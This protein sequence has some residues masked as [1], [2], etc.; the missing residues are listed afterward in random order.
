[1]AKGN[2]GNTVGVSMK[3]KKSTGYVPKASTGSDKYKS[4]GHSKGGYA[5]QVIKK[6]Q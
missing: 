6:G 2:S 4:Y 3:P 5:G 1:M